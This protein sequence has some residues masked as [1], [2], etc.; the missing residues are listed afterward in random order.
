LG[1]AFMLPPESIAYFFSKRGTAG[2]DDSNLVSQLHFFL[3]RTR[4][5]SRIASQTIHVQ[6]NSL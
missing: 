5:R 4:D 1:A 2:S 6:V 3:N